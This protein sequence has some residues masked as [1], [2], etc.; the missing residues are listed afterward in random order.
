MTKIIYNV[1]TEIGRGNTGIGF[2]GL[3]MRLPGIEAAALLCST[4][5]IFED[6]FLKFMQN[7]NAKIISVFKNVW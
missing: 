5:T 4:S 7:F 2:S 6:E 1:V 3:W